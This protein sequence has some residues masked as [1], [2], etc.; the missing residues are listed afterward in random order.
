M[1][2][3]N[4]K[5]FGY[6]YYFNIDFIPEFSSKNKVEFFEKEIINSLFELSTI[7]ISLKNIYIESTKSVNL[8][9]GGSEYTLNPGKHF[10]P[11]C[12]HK[13]HDIFVNP[14][15]DLSETA[16]YECKIADIKYIEA[17]EYLKKYL[18]VINSIKPYYST[19]YTVT[20]SGMICA[21]VNEPI[22]INDIIDENH[23]N[24]I[25]EYKKYGIIL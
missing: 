3:L 1:N 19:N 6:V 7:G 25:N 22:I 13:Y 24:I 23:N 16:I 2:E 21:N 14:N 5:A 8:I 15:Q 10:I 12:L 18:L 11:A 17:I 20:G 9:I 4:K